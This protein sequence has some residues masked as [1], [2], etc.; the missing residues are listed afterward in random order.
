MSDSFE[1]KLPDGDMQAVPRALVRAA[2]RAREIA[3]LT[4]T[5]LVVVRNGVRVEERVDDSPD[6]ALSDS[7][8][9]LLE[10]M[11]DGLSEQELE[12]SDDPG[13]PV[14]L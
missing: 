13:R 1:S 14:N 8:K 9:E 2:R 5:P 7:F 3:R 4:N 6:D 10:Q 12:R 11:P